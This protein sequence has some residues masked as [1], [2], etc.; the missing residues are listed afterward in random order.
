MT[1]LSLVL[2]ATASSAEVL[3]SETLNEFT[4]RQD[5]M[6]KIGSS[7]GAKLGRMK[8]EPGGG[9]CNLYLSFK[10]DGV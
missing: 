6:G 7:F 2:L 8:G 9:T 10:P 4:K 5:F 1:L 3:S